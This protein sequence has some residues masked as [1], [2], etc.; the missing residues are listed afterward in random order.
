[1]T[2][3]M[4]KQQVHA[5]KWLTVLGGAVLSVA[6][7]VLLIGSGVES[8][9]ALRILAPGLGL[10]NPVHNIIPALIVMAVV[11]AAFYCAAAYALVSLLLRALR[12][13]RPQ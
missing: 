1:M 13:R 5:L 12:T 10:I 4:T 3:Y 9:L 2:E 8:G 11:D 7:P 6:V